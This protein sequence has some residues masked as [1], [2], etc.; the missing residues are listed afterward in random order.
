LIGIVG[1][2][3]YHVGPLLWDEGNANG[4]GWLIPVVVRGRG[5][6]VWEKIYKTN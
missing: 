3:I 5:R 6:G 2:P 4:C 1:S